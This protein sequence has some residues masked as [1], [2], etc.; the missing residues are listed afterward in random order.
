MMLVAII[1]SELQS[2]KQLPLSAQ[3]VSWI[4][5]KWANNMVVF[6]R[7]SAAFRPLFVRDERAMTRKMKRKQAGSTCIGWSCLNLE[8]DNS[9]YLAIRRLQ[10][11]YFSAQQNIPILVDRPI[12]RVNFA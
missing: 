4:S 1:E 5:T 11:L 10:Y 3:L 8:I 7:L 6:D 9:I 12:S 2:V